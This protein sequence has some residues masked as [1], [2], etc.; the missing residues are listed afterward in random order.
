MNIIDIIDNNYF[1]KQL[2]PNGIKEF[3]LSHINIDC[4]KNVDLVL[5]TREKPHIEV[6]K[7][8]KWGVNHN[9]ITH[10]ITNNIIKDINISNWGK[11][12]F[13]NCECSIELL[14]ENVHSKYDNLYK[15]TFS[16]DDW[17]VTISSLPFTYQESR[18]YI[19]DEK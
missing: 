4:F 1:L 17:N 6:K 14:E 2:Y 12:K 8:G 18:V 11:S 16:K 9:I 13:E 10:T 15:T 19:L 5:Q 7:W 3:C